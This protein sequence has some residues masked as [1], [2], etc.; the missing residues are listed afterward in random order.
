MLQEITRTILTINTY[1][2]APTVSAEEQKKKRERER[3]GERKDIVLFGHMFVQRGSHVDRRQ[4]CLWPPKK[5]RFP[6]HV[7]TTP[8]FLQLCKNATKDWKWEG[9]VNRKRL[10]R[11][12]ERVVTRTTLSLL[13][14][15]CFLALVSKQT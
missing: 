8:A 1:N 11:P 9:I 5:I 15:L 2:L 7:R 6:W 13:P 14:F 4:Q 3:E 12:R 10:A